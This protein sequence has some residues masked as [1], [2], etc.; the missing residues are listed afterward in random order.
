MSD[1]QVRQARGDDVS[2]LVALHVRAW[3]W[4]YRGQIPDWYLDG[5]SQTIDQR[6][7]WRRAQ[8]QQPDPEERTW[9]VTLAGRVAGFA[10]T[11]SSRD[12]GVGP[13]IAE[14]YSIHI[15]PDFVSRG[16]GRRLLVVAVDDLRQR[17]YRRATLWVLST[18]A[19]ARRFYGAAGW[20][21]DGAA[22]IDALR[23][24]DLHEIR[25]AIDL[26]PDAD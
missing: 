14:L 9:V 20:S 11:G 25:Y 12:E 8:L 18:N 7:A 10:D 21:P 19:R 4:A 22:K 16:L 2:A 24:F 23:G 13:E 26:A 15:D 6:E 17:G 3:Q 1:V 5:L